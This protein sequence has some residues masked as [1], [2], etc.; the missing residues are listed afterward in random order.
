MPIPPKH[1]KDLFYKY[2]NGQC[3]PRE[4]KELLACFNVENES[5]L[6]A[7]ITASLED[8]DAQDQDKEKS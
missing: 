2:L 7:L 4:V 3:S 6:R 8:M 5:V 1:L